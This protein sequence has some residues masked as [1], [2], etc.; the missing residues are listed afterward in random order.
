[1]NQILSNHV[2]VRLIFSF[3]LVIKDRFCFRVRNYKEHP[4]INRPRSWMISF[5]TSMV[6]VTWRPKRRQLHY[7]D[8]TWPSWRL[9]SPTTPQFAQL[10]AQTYTKENIKAP[11]YWSLLGGFTCG[12]PLQ[13]ASNTEN[14][15]IWW[16]QHANRN[17]R[18]RRWRCG[19][20][21]YW[22]QESPPVVWTCPIHKFAYKYWP[23]DQPD[24]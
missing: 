23:S 12:F 7:S 9:K 13:K 5:I 18:L 2:S 8:V 14:A 24:D 21:S 16:R 15:S 1:M 4:Y 10:F 11:R 19:A 17:P 22:P 3:S 6:L 20:I